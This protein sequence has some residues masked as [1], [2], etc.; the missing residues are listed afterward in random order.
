MGLIIYSFG[1]IFVDNVFHNILTGSVSVVTVDSSDH[2]V[3]NHNYTISDHPIS[4]LLNI[5]FQLAVGLGLNL[6]GC[7]FILD[8]KKIFNGLNRYS[9]SNLSGKEK[10]NK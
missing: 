3:E 1:L 10:I 6:I 7:V 9:D 4:Y 5:G 2:M 8:C